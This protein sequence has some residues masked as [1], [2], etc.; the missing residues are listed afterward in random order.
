[1]EIKI[2]ECRMCG[3]KLGQLIEL[4]D[5]DSFIICNSDYIEEWDY[6]ESCMIEHC[7]NTNCYGCEFNKGNYHDCQFFQMKKYYLESEE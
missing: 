3:R 6:C 5:K 1:M 7:V 4:T 2:P